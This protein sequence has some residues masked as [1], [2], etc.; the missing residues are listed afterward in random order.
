MNAYSSQGGSDLY[1]SRLSSGN[2]AYTVM[3]YDA[4]TQTVTV[5]NPW[6]QNE[7]A[8]RDGKDDGIF[9]M[10]LKEFHVNFPVV[11]LSEGTPNAN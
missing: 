9:Q 3:G 2:H 4:K 7:L 1:Q 5:R 10:P 8:D 6:G 11:S